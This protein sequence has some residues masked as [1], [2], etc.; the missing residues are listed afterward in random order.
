MPFSSRFSPASYSVSISLANFLSIPNIM[1]K[2]LLR[3]LFIKK[4]HFPILFS[5][6]HW[7][8]SDVLILLFWAFILA[9]LATSKELN[10]P[11]STHIAFFPR[12]TPLWNRFSLLEHFNLD[13]FKSR[14]S[15]YLSTLSSRSSPY[16]ISF[17]HTTHLICN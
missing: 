9:H 4:F 16:T 14:F 1:K 8:F 15:C 17:I 11:H 12:T 7:K 5:S 10:H 13:L 2:L 3:L 6:F